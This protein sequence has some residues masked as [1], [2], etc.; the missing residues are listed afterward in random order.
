MALLANSI[1]KLS[2]F[3]SQGK[4]KIQLEDYRFGFDAIS[5]EAM[6]NVFKKKKKEEP[7]SK[8]LPPKKQSQ[9]ALKKEMTIV[10][11]EIE[12]EGIISPKITK[13]KSILI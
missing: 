11:E 2:A 7:V 8:E 4:R 3:S 5:A 9:I 1:N 6:K 12:D 10:N 13:K